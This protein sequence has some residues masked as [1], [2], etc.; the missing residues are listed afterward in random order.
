M[1]INY[2]V[3]VKDAKLMDVQKALQQAGIQV[4]SILEIFKEEGEVQA[5]APKD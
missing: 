4:R 2:M 1:N 5:A 3:K